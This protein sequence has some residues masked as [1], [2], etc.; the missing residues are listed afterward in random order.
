MLPVL[1]SPIRLSALERPARPAAP[2][3]MASAAAAARPSASEAQPAGHLKRGAGV[4]QHDVAMRPRARRPGSRARW[5]PRPRRRLPRRSLGRRPRQTERPPGP[6]GS[7]A[8]SPSR[9]SKTAEMPVVV[10][11]SRPSSPRKSF[12][13]VPRRASTSAIRGSMRAS[14]TPTTCAYGPRRVRERPQEVEDRGHAEL[15]P[16]RAR[17]AHRRMEH[18]REHEPDAL[19]LPRH[20]STPAASRSILTPSASSTSADPQW[21]EAARLPCLATGTPAPAIDDRGDG[22]DVEG[23]AA[24]AAGAHDVD[25]R[26]RG[27]HRVRELEHGARQALDLVDGLA[28]GPQGHQEAADLTRRGVAGHH[29]PHGFCGL[30]GGQGLVSDEARSIRGQRSGSGSMVRERSRSHSGRGARYTVDPGG[31]GQPGQRVWFNGRT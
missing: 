18:R 17:V 11:S 7:R 16:D 23:A 8:P 2:E 5:P 3:S 24:I 20:R 27:V 12:A 9:T 15:A 4:Q 30:I 25:H 1:T 6:G 29:G 10:S 31:L 22:R 28:L 21:L 19:R 13:A 26:D 14:E